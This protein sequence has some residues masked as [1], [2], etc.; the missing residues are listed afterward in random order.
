MILLPAIDLIDGN[1][2]RLKE[3]RFDTAEKVAEDPLTTA[4]AFRAAGAAWIHMVDLDGARTGTGQNREIVLAVA[5]ES[6]LQVEV[7]GGIRSAETVKAYLEGGV[8]RVILGSAAVRDPAFV[9]EMVKAWGG[10][11]AVGIDARD[12]MVQAGG[13][14]EGSAVHYLELARA[15]ESAGVGTIIFTDISKDGMMGGP[16]L[17]QLRRIREAVSCQIIASG[18]VSCMEDLRQVKAMGCYGAIIG[19]AI[20]NGGIDLLR[21]VAELEG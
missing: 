5:R 18:G 3:G 1:C 4:A 11:I 6:G 2:V 13:W 20:Y 16:N 9:K 19:K 7:G 21:A 14:L 15:M 12:G 17:E 8:A 10:R